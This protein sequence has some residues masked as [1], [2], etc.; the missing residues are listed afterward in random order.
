MAVNCI[1]VTIKILSSAE[2]GLETL[3]P[4]APTAQYN[5]S[6]T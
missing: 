1:A 6:Y 2:F 4:V 3:N 5:T